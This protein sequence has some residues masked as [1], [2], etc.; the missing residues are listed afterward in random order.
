MRL[1]SQLFRCF[2]RAV[3]GAGG[4]HADR[5]DSQEALG[6]VYLERGEPRCWRVETGRVMLLMRGLVVE[7]RVARRLELLDGHPGMSGKVGPNESHQSIA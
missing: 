4:E 2:G 3:V 6:H 5:W 1:K 7:F